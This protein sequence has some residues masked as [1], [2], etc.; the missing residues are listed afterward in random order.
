MMNKSKIIKGAKA[1]K[2]QKQILKK[3]KLRN[4]VKFIHM[5]PVCLKLN[6]NF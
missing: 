2:A 1:I 5:L 6:N 3:I 4:K